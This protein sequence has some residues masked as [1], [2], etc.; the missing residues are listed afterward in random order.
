M[1][2]K[3]L[4]FL[5]IPKAA[6]TTLHS[7][8]ERRYPKS[9][10][11]SMWEDQERHLAELAQWPESRRNE[12]R[13]LKGHFAYGVHQHLVGPSTYVT[14]L[15][16]PVARVISHYYYVRCTPRH[17]L[18]EQMMRD[19]VTLAEYISMKITKEIDNDQVRLLSGVC[20][21]LP[22]GSLGQE[23]LEAAKHNVER[24]FSVVGTSDRFDESLALMGIELGWNWT[25]YYLEQNVAKDKRKSAPVETAILDNIRHE[26]QLD[27]ELYLWVQARFDAAL[28]RHRDEVERRLV[29]LRRA[30]LIHRPLMN[31]VATLQ[32]LITG[33][34][35]R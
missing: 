26:N 17:Y 32:S 25:P 20:H 35:K 22:Y 7:I 5:H 1:E 3:N 31:M 33:R 29:Q 24:H 6:G 16:D 13:L 21:S 2:Y 4:I 14:L 12:L 11:Y 8:L 28:S 18:Y 23:H 10:S 27:Y 30:N 9:A 34:E 19:N 15:R